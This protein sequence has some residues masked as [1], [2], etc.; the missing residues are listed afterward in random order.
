[1]LRAFTAAD[2]GAVRGL[3]LGGMRERWGERFDPAAN[4][5]VDDM[6]AHYVVEAHGEIVVV[7]I[8]GVV[9]A[10]GTL[11][12]EPADDGES[13]SDG[14]VGRIVRMAVDPQ[15]RRQGL[16]RRVVAELVERARSHGWHRVVVETDTPW[17]SAVALYAA[18][19]FTV[20]RQTPTETHF[21]LSLG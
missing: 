2:Q 20:E 17:T 3:I 4:P 11:L 21:V 14:K 16:G 15:V 18:C 13:D 5:K 7:E 1:M 19:G 12:P 9:V 10:T 6:W 8:D